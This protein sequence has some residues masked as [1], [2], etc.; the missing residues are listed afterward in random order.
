MEQ[1]S[2]SSPGFFYGYV[3]VT[4]SFVILALV[5]GT[6]YSFGVFFKPML[7]DF[8]WTRA[9][10][11]GALS[12]SWLTGGLFSIVIGGFNDR[13]G[14]RIMMT[15]C[16]VFSALGY[17]LMSQI[18][19]VWQLYVFYGVVIGIGSCVFTPAAATIARWFIQRRTVM[20]GV[21][22]SG[23]GIGILI[24]PV[25][26]DQLIQAY[27][28]RTSFIIIGIAILVIATLAAQ[29]I[30]SDP[31]RMGQ[32][33]YGE[34]DL[35]TGYRHVDIPS[36]SLKETIRTWQFWMIFLMLVCYG[37]CLLSIQVHLVPYLTDIGFSATIAASLVALPGGTSIIGRI[38][39][40][41]LG[42]KI[43]NK[44]G[45][46][47]GFI[48][49][50]VSVVLLLSTR[51]IWGLYLFAAIFGIAYGT[52]AVQQS[53][54]L[55][56]LFGVRSLG[57]IFGVAGLGFT[58]GAAAGPFISGYIFDT[59]RSY[60]LAFIICIIVCAIG[61]A[62]NIILKPPQSKPAAKG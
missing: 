39:L 4:A 26:A 11:S 20:T 31:H 60:F 3:V 46:I 22:I 29:F 59:T 61:L 43:G 1:K 12:L 49:L 6:Y 25:V 41:I 54:L 15:I 48:L 42:D 14:A 16:S 62:L 56:A 33:A 28:W 45:F 38:P 44:K 13:F 19:D 55:A 7:A 18:S 27:G 53:P 58:L 50:L 40:G 34:H 36:L 9:L 10:T 30:R 35:A 8:G 51:E 52:C 2:S 57:L 47:V 32:P 37:Y 21:V 17:L 23:V 24:V 5:I